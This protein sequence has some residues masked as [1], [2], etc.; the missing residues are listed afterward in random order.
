MFEIQAGIYTYSPILVMT[1]AQQLKSRRIEANLSQSELALKAG[2][3]KQYINN[4]ENNTPHPITGAT[5]R[6]SREKVTAIANALGWNLAEAL[7]LAGYAPPKHP[8]TDDFDK[9]EFATLFYDYTHNLTE[10][11][12]KE[13]A[14]ILN[15]FKAEV[16][17]RKIH[18]VP[19]RSKTKKTG[20]Q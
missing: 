12:R 11:D 1:F 6:P 8:S 20:I 4:L 15:A 14:A 18:S 7:P 13:L 19:P 17:R 16:R 9:S 3:S 5:P 2:T 10:D